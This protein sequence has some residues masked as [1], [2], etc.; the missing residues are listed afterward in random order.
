MRRFILVVAWAMASACGDRPSPRYP[1][2][3]AAASAPPDALAPGPVPAPV[4]FT[5]LPPLVFRH[6][7]P[8]ELLPIAKYV[9][10][11]HA[12]SPDA[13]S[14][15]SSNSSSQD[16]KRPMKEGARLFTPS[17]PDGVVFDSWVPSARFFADGSRVL[18]WSFG[19]GAL[20]VL[21]VA[22]GRTVFERR[23][24][25]C[26]A[27]FDGPDH[28]VF[29]ESS[30]ESDAR[31]WR[32]EI[33]SGKVAALGAPRASEFCE[34]SA[35]GSAWIA[36]YDQT[37]AFVDGRTGA[38]L[39]IRPPENAAVTLSPGANRYCLP[40]ETDLSCVH[41]PDGGSERVWSRATSEYMVFGPDGQ[42]ALVRYITS[43]EGV[44]D[45]YAWVDFAARTVRVLSGFRSYSG[46]TPLIHPGG[47]LVSAGSG[48]GLYVY[49]MERGTVR[50]AAH[51]PLYENEIDVNNPRRVVVGTDNVKDEFYVDV[52]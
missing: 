42:H 9:Y 28:V 41:L 16:G 36:Y 2:P 24:T 30:K 31:L 13:R 44:Y 48:S 35:D 4:T 49:D 6:G 17:F 23:A 39:A 1:A 15:V 14:W 26:A 52:R 34:A 11:F 25:V 20:A 37:R 8:L 3:S 27:R 50:F 32:V 43:P 46:S 22:T 33:S 29:H 5:E 45:G 12:L 19:G 10:E 40:S 7:A 47:K 51:R 38:A 21:D 18:V